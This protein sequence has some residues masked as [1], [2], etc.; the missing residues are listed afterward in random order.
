MIEH[1]PGGLTIVGE[2]YES[3]EFSLSTGQSLYNLKTGQSAFVVA[4]QFHHVILRTD[5]DITVRLNKNTN[6]GI[7]IE[8]G[9]T[10]TTDGVLI[11]NIFITNASGNTAAIKIILS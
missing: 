2:K 1:G 7:T 9:S 11:T 4:K 3:K 8:A 5:N 6:D 10:F